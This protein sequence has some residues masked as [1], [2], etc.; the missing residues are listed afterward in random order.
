MKK[1]IIILTLLFSLGSFSFAKGIPEYQTN[2]YQAVNKA[3]L[4]SH[5]IPKD[6]VG[7]SN[8]SLLNDRIVEQTKEV[9]K[10][11]QSK[12]RLSHDEQNILNYYLSYYDMKTRNTLGIK[13]IKKGLSA[14]DA[15]KHSNDLSQIFVM[16][17]E[18]ITDLPIAMGMGADL[19]DSTQYIVT[20]GQGGTSLLKKHYALKDEDAKKQMKALKHLFA[21]LFTLAGYDNVEKR[22]ANAIEVERTL[23]EVQWDLLKHRDPTYTYHIMPYSKIKQMLSNLDMDAMLKAAHIPLDVTFN[24]AEP[25]YLKALNGLLKKIGIE[26]WK[27]Y[28]RIHYISSYSGMLSKD[29]DKALTAQQQELG[30]GEKEPSLEDRAISLVQGSDMLFGKVY[31]EHFFDKGSKE[32]IKEIITR[33]KE[34]YEDAITHSQRLSPSTKKAALHKFHTM[35]FNIGYPDKW[36]DFSGLELKADDL[37]GNIQRFSQFNDLRESKKL[38]GKVDREEWG[39]PPQAINAYYSPQTNKF[40][41][42]AAILQKPF[43]DANGSAAVNY[44]GIGF[45]I[46][47]EMGHGFDDQGSRF[48]F[49]GNMKD[50]WTA[51]DHAK[52][53]AL[54]KELI[55]QADKYEVLP[56]KFA[57][58]ELEIGEII[59]D[60]SGAEIALRAFLKEVEAKGLPRKEALRAFFMQ[61]A[62]TWRSKY[63][64]QVKQMLLDTDP[65]PADEYRANGTVKNMDAFYEAFDVKEGDKM[66]L[67]PEERVKIW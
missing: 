8:F 54:K 25:S 32:K 55:V 29:F 40:V 34:T 60:V 41:L 66:W 1:T 14:I 36:I 37:I 18:G 5:S 20:V 33:I 42:L 67:K 64:Q 22:V 46:G 23:S 15:V 39:Y 35:K 10:R 65:H 48:D 59:A 47:H 58:G 38:G 57:K 27:D 31:V 24:V 13:P 61:L 43:F 28:A 19:N 21:K 7:V 9:I 6:Q 17:E 12:K 63:L 3:W 49:E 44:G 11:L 50:W 16:F 2:F 56:G 4:S 62:K 51:E 52:F 53:D 30:L 26:K 45:V